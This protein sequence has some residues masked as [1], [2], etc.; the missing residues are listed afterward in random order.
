M[1]GVGSWTV[2]LH[3]PCLQHTTGPG[4][5]HTQQG[6]PRVWE[7]GRWEP[8]SL[9]EGVLSPLQLLPCQTPDCQ[10]PPLTLVLFSSETCMADMFHQ[11]T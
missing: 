2:Q 5:L 7:E 10:R 9:G 1:V 4:E 8:L 3:G 11:L 6:G